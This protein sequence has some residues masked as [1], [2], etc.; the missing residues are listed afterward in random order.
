[1]INIVHAHH[2]ATIQM[3]TD[4]DRTISRQQPSPPRH[5][6]QPI[7][8]TSSCIWINFM[9]YGRSGNR[10]IQLHHVNE[11][12]ARCSGVAVTRAGTNDDTTVFF[13]PT[14][15]ASTFPNHNLVSYKA[16]EAAA[17]MCHEVNYTSAEFKDATNRCGGSGTQYRL[18]QGWWTKESSTGLEQ[19]ALLPQMVVEKRAWEHTFDKSTMLMYF[20]GGDIL[21]VNPHP[22][23]SQ[24]PCSLFLES[25]NLI[26]PER[27]MLIYDRNDT[28]NP[29]VRVVERHIPAYRRIQPPCDGAGCHMTLIGRAPYV[30]V[31]GVSTFAS[32]SFLLFPEQKRVVFKYFC[33]EEPRVDG[34]T[35]HLCVN[36][37]TQGF[38][39]WNYTDSTRDLMLNISSGVVLGVFNASYFKEHVQHTFIHPTAS[40]KPTITIPHPHPETMAS[41][42]CHIFH[43]QGTWTA[44]YS[45]WRLL[46]EERRQPMWDLND[47][48]DIRS[49]P[50]QRPRHILLAGDSTMA[51]FNGR[52]PLKAM[53]GQLPIVAKRS[54]R[55]DLL[56]YY[57]LA[58]ATEWIAPDDRL[59]GPVA[60]GLH[61][62]FCTD[63]RGCNAT[64]RTVMDAATNDTWTYEFLPVEFA[65]D[66]EFPTAAGATTSQEAV[67]QYLA[68][69]YPRDLCVLSAAIHDVILNITAVRFADNVLDYLDIV[70]PFCS[71]I[72]WLLPSASLD[73]PPQTHQ[74]LLEFGRELET[75]CGRMGSNVLLFN[76][77]DMSLPPELHVDNVHH[78]PSHYEAL[79]KLLLQPHLFA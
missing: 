32:N 26:A 63:C 34:N 19:L 53:H 12:L 5:D 78:A 39:P 22:K 70:R 59:E 60:F 75:R 4:L 7:F 71:K 33:N 42:R 44:N 67:G 51:R 43:N 28:I 17:R 76:I 3:T 65:R 15:I 45:S 54:S 40:A 10:L 23:Y 8:N 13:P 21:H 58:R 16:L 14:L 20:R 79:G 72:I 77:W 73:R 56:E 9:P 31:S 1:M 35:L 11:I 50:D 25:W 6:E 52:L 66:R 2:A 64:L 61:N 30:V 24:A 29:C 49:L 27:A 18:Q 46:D 74:R 36:G 47:F 57:G 41:S 37:S 48:V 68:A 69:T 62:S 38:I 55:C